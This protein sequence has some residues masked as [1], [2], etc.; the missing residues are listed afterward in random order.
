MVVATRDVPPGKELTAEDL[1]A[2]DVPTSVVP[3]RGVHQ[4][5]R[6]VGRVG[7][8]APGEGPGRARNTAGPH[9][10]GDGLGALVPDGMRAMTM[11]IDE[12][13]G[14]GGMIVPGC[15][16]DVMAIVPD[17]QTKQ[18]TAR[19]VL[20]NLKIDRGGPAVYA[21]VRRWTASRPRRNNLTFL[22]TPDQARMLQL[23]G[24]HGPPV[25]GPAQ[26]P[27]RSAAQGGSN[28]H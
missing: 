17:E 6:P 18:Q 8:L 5:S 28:Q 4:R 10:S 11:N 13:T 12:I 15:H 1:T 9:G 16:V 27:R 19:T 21:A 2:A 26:R 25:A 20:Q 3:A 7:D 22:V 14:L 23:G 24:Q